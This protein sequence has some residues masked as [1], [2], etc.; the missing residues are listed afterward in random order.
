M[1]VKNKGVV[2][3]ENYFVWR[4]S[5]VFANEEGGTALVRQDDRIISIAVKGPGKKELLCDLRETMNDIFN[6]FKSR[7]PELQYRIEE[8]PGSLTSPLQRILEP[9]WLSDS[10][11][12]K[13]ALAGKPYFDD[14]TGIVEQL[15][16][17]KSLLNKSVKGVKN[18]ISITKEIIKAYNAIHGWMG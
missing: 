15:S 4:Y 6:G 1:Y 18:G 10:K 13:H 11:I 5:V 9:L 12:L 3:G 2:K 7:K 14:R 8:E 17:E 16:D